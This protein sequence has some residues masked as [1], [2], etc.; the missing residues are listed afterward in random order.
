MY[1]QNTSL[2]PTGFDFFLNIN[3]NYTIWCC[4]W[5]NL[6]LS[7]PK[8]QKMHVFKLLTIQNL[9]TKQDKVNNNRGMFCNHCLQGAYQYSKK[10]NY[11]TQNP[12]SMVFYGF[13]RSQTLFLWFSMVFGAK[14]AISMGFGHPARYNKHTEEGWIICPKN[15]C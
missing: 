15:L 13:G 8:E 5:E 6:P 7:P 10:I 4:R 12:I 1:L 11:Y 9:K 3:Q 14:S 2:K